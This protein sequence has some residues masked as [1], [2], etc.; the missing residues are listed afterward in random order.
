MGIEIIT[1]DMFDPDLMSVDIEMYASILTNQNKV[2]SNK[3]EKLITKKSKSEKAEEKK[4]AII[5][6]LKSS[7]PCNNLELREAYCNWIDSIYD[8]PGGFLSKSAIKIFADTINNYTKGDLDVA[9]E[10]LKLATV[11]SYKNA[12]WVINLYEKDRNSLRT[13]TNRFDKDVS[14]SDISY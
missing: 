8:K 2:V 1:K 13:T 10:L 11:K 7:I 12:D 4:R 5:E 9:L 6:G 14:L 3:V